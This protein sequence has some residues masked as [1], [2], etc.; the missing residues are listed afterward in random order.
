MILDFL[1]T[2]CCLY[3]WIIL[4]NICFILL[5]QFWT[6]KIMFKNF[7]ARKND[8]ANK[9]LLLRDRR[10]A[11]VNLAYNQEI[12]SKEQYKRG[13]ELICFVKVHLTSYQ[14]IVMFLQPMIIFALFLPY[15]GV[16]VHKWEQKII[17]EQINQGKKK[18]KKLQALD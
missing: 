15:M 5:V 12:E 3:F 1:D 10:S 4:L 18:K 9:K 8:S 17:R 13:S 11:N 7:Q 2:K 6:F 14:I 16:C